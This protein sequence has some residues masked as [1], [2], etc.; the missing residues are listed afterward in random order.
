M[1]VD[2]LCMYM[3]RCVGGN[4]PTLWPA[5]ETIRAIGAESIGR[6]WG[7]GG[8]EGA[9]PDFGYPLEIRQ[10]EPLCQ[11]CHMPVTPYVNMRKGQEDCQVTSLWQLL[12]GYVST[13]DR[14]NGNQCLLVLGSKCS[15]CHT[16]HNNISL[17]DICD[18]RGLL[19]LV[20]AV[21]R[22]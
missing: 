22:G 12:G 5:I 15:H 9:W 14:I 1:Y 19:I 3:S 2:V 16:F 21:I 20:R 17:F 4:C 8:T 13:Y 10:E 18:N 6:G 7:E 11:H